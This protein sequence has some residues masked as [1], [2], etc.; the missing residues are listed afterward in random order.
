MINLTNFISEKIGDFYSMSFGL[1]LSIMGVYL[2]FPL[3]PFPQKIIY[4]IIGLSLIDAGGPFIFILGLISLSKIVKKI[5]SNYDQNTI[6]D[7]AS[8]MN[9][10]F[11]SIGD[12]SGPIIGGFLSSS[13]NFKICCIILSIT[14]FIFF[15][16]FLFFY[17]KNI[18]DNTDDKNIIAN[19]NLELSRQLFN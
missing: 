9:N 11:I 12:L 17:D 6:N 1:F 4:I 8:A 3:P 5:N 19:N 2:I 14:F 10:L 7:I 16:I 18:N 13:F 15:I